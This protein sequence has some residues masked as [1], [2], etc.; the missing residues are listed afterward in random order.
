LTRSVGETRAEHLDI[1][2]TIAD[3]S[4]RFST[5]STVPRIRKRNGTSLTIPPSTS[6]KKFEKAVENSP[7]AGK[8][9]WVFKGAPYPDVIVSISFKR[10]PA[11]KTHHNVGGLPKRNVDGQ[12]LKLIEPLR[13]LLKEAGLYNQISQAYAAVV[14]KPLL[15]IPVA[16]ASR[17]MM[18]LTI[19]YSTPAKPSLW[20]LVR[21]VVDWPDQNRKA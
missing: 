15:L 10:S 3:A 5:A 16:V 13:E 8:I 4:Q 21:V 2:L 12:G 1:N 19:L 6:S 14:H 18:V 9:E 17:L 11:T 7:T 20:S